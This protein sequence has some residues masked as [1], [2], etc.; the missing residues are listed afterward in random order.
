MSNIIDFKSRKIKSDIKKIQ[1]ENEDIE[2]VESFEDIMKKNAEN[3]ERER[4]ER[5]RAN[6]GVKRSH[7]LNKK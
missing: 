6:N 1:D 3:K 5:M 4:K 2:E 7:R